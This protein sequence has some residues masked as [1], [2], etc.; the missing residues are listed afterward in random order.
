MSS[1]GFV[2]ILWVLGLDGAVCCR[3][4]GDVWGSGVRFGGWVVIDL[5]WYLRVCLAGDAWVALCGVPIEFVSWLGVRV[6]GLEGFG[7]C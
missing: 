3:F 7:L 2:V 4:A 6:S 5:V 1:L